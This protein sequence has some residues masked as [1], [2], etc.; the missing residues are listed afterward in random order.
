ML[1]Y[2]G[3][4]LTH[5]ISALAKRL[6]R[7]PSPCHHASTQRDGS[8]WEPG[9]GSSPECRHLGT[10]ILDFRPPKPWEINVCWKPPSPWYIVMA[11][12]QAKT[13]TKASPVWKCPLGCHLG[14]GVGHLGWERLAFVG[15]QILLR[16][17]SSIFSYSPHSPVGRCCYLPPLRRRKRGHR[18]TSGFAQAP[19][20]LGCGRVRN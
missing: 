15:G 5:G 10:L 17:F 12:E 18:E 19:M 7:D 16:G 20:Q 14:V 4:A 1:K 9:R 3:G 2:E 13:D 8:S 6:Q 11:A